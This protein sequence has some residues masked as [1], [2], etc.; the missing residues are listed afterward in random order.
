M[1]KVPGSA[2]MPIL[3]Y[4]PCFFHCEPEFIAGGQY[5]ISHN[6]ASFHVLDIHKH[7]G[8]LAE[9]PANYMITFNIHVILNATFD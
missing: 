6:I 8:F 2:Y 7:M 5:N 3:H 1:A 9:W 4:R